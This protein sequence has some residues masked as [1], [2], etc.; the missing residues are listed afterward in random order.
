MLPVESVA[1]TPPSHRD[2]KPWIAACAYGALTV[3]VLAHF[4]L[5]IPIQLTDSFGNMLKLESTWFELLRDEFTQHAF[6]RPFLLAQLKLVYDVSGGHYFAWFRGVHVAQIAVLVALYLHLAQPRTWR[7]AAVVPLGLAVLFGVHTFAGTV[8]EAFPINTFLTIVLC[9]LAAATMSLARPRWWI[10]V[11]A[12][13]L[14]VVA[15][16]TVESG[17]LVGVILIGGALLGGRGVSRGALACI[18]AAGAG[19]F[20]LRFVL[21]DVGSPGLVERSSGFGARVLEPAEL[22]ARFGSNPLPFYAYNVVTSAISVLFGEPRGG[23]FQLLTD[24]EDGVAPA[25]LL[26]IAASLAGTSLIGWYAWSRRAAWR[27]RDFERD[28]RLVLLFLFVLVANAAISYAYTKDVIMSPAGAFYA[29]A[30]FAALR[31]FLARPVARRAAA[32]TVAWCLVLSATWTVRDVALHMKLRHMATTVRTE[33]AH[34][35]TW[36]QDQNIPLTTVRARALFKRLQHE[37]IIAR[38]A[39]PVLPVMDH[40]LLEVE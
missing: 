5:G 33:W 39:P 31:H 6:L 29:V 19:Y 8:T 35:E 24:R 11:G 23:V 38:P 32:G 20:V 34:A 28:D 27:A 2:R 12:V 10:D 37:A 13:L 30:L 7:D 15:A 3:A 25:T 21:L 26:N 18:A 14:F 9:C 1:E 22:I 4:L 16:L 17:L 36:L 40:P